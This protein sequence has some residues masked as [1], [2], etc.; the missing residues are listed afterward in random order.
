MPI[1]PNWGSIA[2]G[3]W[4]QVKI[5]KNSLIFARCGLRP[6]TKVCSYFRFRRYVFLIPGLSKNDIAPQKKMLNLSQFKSSRELYPAFWSFPAS[7]PH[8]LQLVS[9]K[10]DF[11]SERRVAIIFR[12][13]RGVAAA[14]SHSERAAGTSQGVDGFVEAFTIKDDVQMF[15]V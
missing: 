14:P 6:V 2:I 9:L 1:Q 8:P 5:P 11:L 13:V 3:E 4:I 12:R 10:E 7:F 15:F